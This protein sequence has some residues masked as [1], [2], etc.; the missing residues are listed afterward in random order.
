MF[1]AREYDYAFF[2]FTKFKVY[3]YKTMKF[4]TGT[5]EY[6]SLLFFWFT[7]PKATKLKVP[8]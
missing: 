6:F 3:K 2:I 8:I 1:T 4:L 7:L 5:A